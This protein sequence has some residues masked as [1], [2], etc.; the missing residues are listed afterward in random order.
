MASANSPT[1]ETSLHPEI[2]SI[3]SLA[4]AHAQ[5]IY[6][7]GRLAHKVESVTFDSY[8]REDES[9]H[10]VWAQLSGTT[11]S[12]EKVNTFGRQDEKVPPTYVDVTDVVRPPFHLQYL[13]DSTKP[14]S[15]DR[16]HPQMR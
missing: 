7:S 8:L 12:I 13:H 2:P 15:P 9:Y 4:T 5:K 6:F 10:D 11:L 16:P 1:D 14:S 3:G